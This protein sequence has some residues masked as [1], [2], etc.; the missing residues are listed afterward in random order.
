MVSSVRDSSVLALASRADRCACCNCP[1][2]VR[3]INF[4]RSTSMVIL[5]TRLDNMDTICA[6]ALY[7]TRNDIN[8]SRSLAVDDSVVV[9]EAEAEADRLDDW[10]GRPNRPVPGPLDPTQAPWFIQLVRV[11][12][13]VV[14]LLVVTSEAFFLLA[15]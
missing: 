11:L 10:A 1:S 4:A 3:A 5:L 14:L 7:S 2:M 9:E 15:L 6:C 12:A 8:S 13:R